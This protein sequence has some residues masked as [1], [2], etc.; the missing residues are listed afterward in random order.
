M[1]RNSR[2]KKGLPVP[3][4]LVWLGLVSSLIVYAAGF[5]PAR[6]FEGLVNLTQL[7]SVG[8]TAGVGSVSLKLPASQ[9]DYVVGYSLKTQWV[10]NNIPASWVG[11]L[12]LKDAAG[13][14][15][16]ES[17]NSSSPVS[18]A[19]NSYI[20]TL[21]GTPNLGL[22]NL[23]LTFTNPANGQT[24]SASQKINLVANPNLLLRANFND[25]TLAADLSWDL[26]NV[27]S[28]WL[29]KVS[30]YGPGI[31]NRVVKDKLPVTRTSGQ[32]SYP[33]DYMAAGSY[34]F[35]V[36]FY[37]PTKTQT[38]SLKVTDSVYKPE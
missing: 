34:Q 20:F 18:S 25:V 24:V 13:V 3:M 16:Y 30:V 37:D 19:N 31:F 5:L 33:L 17:K 12:V 11:E 6:P 26:V 4:Y 38:G 9:R 35:T 1:A 29:G 27:P 28:H 2:N 23:I 14:V 7:G 36:E 22:A 21:P 10:K 8:A 15:I 32:F